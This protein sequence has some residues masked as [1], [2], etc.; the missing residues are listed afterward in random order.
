M[1]AEKLFHAYKVLCI[2]IKVRAGVGP[3]GHRN[4]LIV[5]NIYSHD[6][7]EFFQFFG[8]IRRE[9]LFLESSSV[10]LK[11]VIF[12]VTGSSNKYR[13]PKIRLV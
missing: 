9:G 11:E 3:S 10:I 7:F 6:I 1:G 13:I 4:N 2:K 5:K 8:V 12:Q